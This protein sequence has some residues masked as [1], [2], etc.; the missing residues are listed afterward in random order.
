VDSWSDY[1]NLLTHEFVLSPKQ[2][3]N[4]GLLDGLRENTIFVRN[5]FRSVHQFHSQHECDYLLSRDGHYLSDCNGTAQLS[6]LADTYYSVAAENIWPIGTESWH[7]Q[8]QRQQRQPIVYL[9][10]VSE[11]SQLAE[12]ALENELTTAQSQSE[13]AVTSKSTPLPD[14]HSTALFPSN[15]KS[16]VLRHRN[17]SHGLPEKSPRTVPS[18][19]SLRETLPSFITAIIIAL[20]LWPSKA[21]R[22][23]FY[24]YDGDGPRSMQLH[25]VPELWYFMV[26]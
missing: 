26:P 10:T 7:F 9:R 23:F 16:L 5:E 15:T 25:S 8:E 3:V 14:S 6:F 1:Q 12:S 13:L 24:T 18:S 22:R 4:I 11:A 19:S 20:T 21:H 17:L 2:S